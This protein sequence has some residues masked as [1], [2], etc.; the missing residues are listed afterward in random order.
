MQILNVSHPT[1]ASLL[2]S[3][4]IEFL[5]QATE[6]VDASAVADIMEFLNIVDNSY[7]ASGS[8]N[9]RTLIDLSEELLWWHAVDHLLDFLSDTLVLSPV[10]TCRLAVCLLNTLAIVAGN[11]DI[12]TIDRA[13]LD[14][15]HYLSVFEEQLAHM[16]DES[17]ESG[18]CKVASKLL[19][20][21]LID[22][23]LVCIRHKKSA[24]FSS[25]AVHKIVDVL[26]LIWRSTEPA[27]LSDVLAHG[28]CKE[29][30]GVMWLHPAVMWSLR[31]SI[32]THLYRALSSSV[33]DVCVSD[34]IVSLCDELKPVADDIDRSVAELNELR[35]SPQHQFERA[36]F[37]VRHRLAG[38]KG[39]HC[40][41]LCDL[42]V[43][44]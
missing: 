3:K 44:T 39:C 33:R 10:T 23:P 19:E 1:T 17:E 34:E 24:G 43:S 7:I 28:R 18:G 16:H 2:L 31:Q 21:S 32:F 42:L 8:C 12:L 38:H 5:G 4:F 15:S 41:C 11:A 14:E 37:I 30:V 36:L 26:R 13:C 29:S 20:Y 40:N 6:S 25:Q 27:K 35:Q 9:E 22:M